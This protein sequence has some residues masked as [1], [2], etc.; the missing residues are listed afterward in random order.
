MDPA[1][2]IDTLNEEEDLESEFVVD[3]EYESSE[4]QHPHSNNTS[5]PVLNA[6]DSGSEDYR[7]ST[8]KICSALLTTYQQQIM[9]R[10]ST[11]PAPSP[12]L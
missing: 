11:P 1:R 3:S 9:M 7:F 5:L 12:Q 10:F 8:G 2:D 6:L 4:H